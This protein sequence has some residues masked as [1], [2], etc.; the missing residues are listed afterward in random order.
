MKKYP[1]AND[2]APT[3]TATDANRSC[4]RRDG[5]TAATLPSSQP[6]KKKNTAQFP[7]KESQCAGEM[8]GITSVSIS[9]YGS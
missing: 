8:V 7:L 6:I 1:N 3:E 5:S 9:K 2:A 4:W